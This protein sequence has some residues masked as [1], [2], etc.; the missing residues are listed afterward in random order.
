MQNLEA[1]IIL[2]AK[3]GTRKTTF[4]RKDLRVEANDLAPI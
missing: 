4:N 3:Q 2:V 1:L